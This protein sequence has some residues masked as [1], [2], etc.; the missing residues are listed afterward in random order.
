MLIFP[1]SPCPFPSTYILTNSL[2]LLGNTSNIHM[3]IENTLV[4]SNVLPSSFIKSQHYTTLPSPNAILRP[5]TGLLD[6]RVQISTGSLTFHI[7]YISWIMP[8]AP[9]RTS[10]F[11]W[12]GTNQIWPEMATGKLIRWFPWNEP[13]TVKAM[14]IRSHPQVL[15][16]EKKCSGKVRIFNKN[17]NYDS[18]HRSHFPLAFLGSLPLWHW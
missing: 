6:K 14:Q 15:G 8:R 1:L 3:K 18:Q 12:V 9:L 16:L 17:G 5:N 11:L 7:S 13:L 2:I 4:N 10:A